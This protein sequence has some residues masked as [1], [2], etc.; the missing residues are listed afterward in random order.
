MDG[1]VRVFTGEGRGKTSA[2]MGLALRAIGAGGRIYIARFL[3]AW[4]DEEWK[5]FTRLDGDVVFRQFGRRGLMEEEPR[6]GDFR[7]AREALDEIRRAM[8]SGTYSLVILDDVNLATCL[9]FFCVE[10]LLALI[11]AKPQQVELVITGCCADP[12][13]IR[14]ADR[15]TEMQEVKGKGGMLKESI[16]C[17]N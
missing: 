10:D 1:L 3:R 12:R 16:F 7:E 5:G 13:I 4:E 2:A 15:V 9:G 14:K 8:R 11:E 6:E 17:A